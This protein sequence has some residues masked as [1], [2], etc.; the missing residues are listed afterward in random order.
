MGGK[1]NF[2]DRDRE[3]E[4]QILQKQSKYFRQQKTDHFFKGSVF[5]KNLQIFRNENYANFLICATNLD[6]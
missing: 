4:K 3:I 5:S 6:L 2:C 1:K